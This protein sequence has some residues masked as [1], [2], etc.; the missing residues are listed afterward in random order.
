MVKEDVVEVSAV[1]NVCDE[2]TAEPRMWFI[3]SAGAVPVGITSSLGNF[4]G[5]DDGSS[6]SFLCFLWQAPCHF[7]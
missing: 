6:N 7:Q 4:F 1:E 3:Y 5:L 2:M